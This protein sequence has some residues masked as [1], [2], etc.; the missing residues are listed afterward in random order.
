[1]QRGKLGWVALFALG[2]AYVEAASVVYL[3]RL[4]DITDLIRDVAPYDR[5][6]IG[7]AHV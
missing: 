5:V 6:Q 7:R 1:M 4:Y 2:M 3:R